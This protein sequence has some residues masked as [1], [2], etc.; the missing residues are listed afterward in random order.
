LGFRALI[1]T[2]IYADFFEFVLQTFRK[3]LLF[4][5]LLEKMWKRCRNYIHGPKK[6]LSQKQ[7]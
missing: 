1:I 3:F 2:K 4:L 7:R 5:F 6:G